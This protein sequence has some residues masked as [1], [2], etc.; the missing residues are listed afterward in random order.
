MKVATINISSV[1]IH[2]PE[3]IRPDTDR[4][5]G[6]RDSASNTTN[7]GDTTIT[8][9]VSIR[10]FEAPAPETLN[11]EAF[12][13][14]VAQPMDET[15]VR[16]IYPLTEAGGSV[17]EAALAHVIDEYTIEIP[18]TT[19]INLFL[20]VPLPSL[21]FP[22]IPATRTTLSQSCSPGVITITRSH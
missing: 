13:V 20:P 16:P 10:V 19:P 7:T 15:T 5:G 8:Y 3:H 2:T 21:P 11:D 12:R 22:P 17:A 9:L 1:K 18:L 6:Q 4:D 14:V